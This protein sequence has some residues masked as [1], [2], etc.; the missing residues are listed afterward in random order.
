MTSAAGAV[1][2]GVRSRDAAVILLARSATSY[3]GTGPARAPAVAA[4]GRLAAL[5]DL[6]FTVRPEML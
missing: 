4:L 1:S 5:D 3:F 6:I 2:S